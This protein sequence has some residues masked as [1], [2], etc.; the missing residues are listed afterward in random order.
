MSVFRPVRHLLSL[1]AGLALAGLA[2]WMPALAAPWS[3]GDWK[4]NAYIDR[5]GRFSHCMMSARYNSGISLHFL[6][7][8][9]RDLFIGVAAPDWSLDPDSLY[10]MTLT[11]DG[12]R[13][14][15]APGTVLKYD[16]GRL[17]LALGRDRQTRERL[18]QGL[19]LQLLQG[20]RRYAFQLTGT[21]KALLRLE[22]C[23]DEDDARDRASRIPNALSPS[24]PRHRK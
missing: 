5:S 1:S 6:M 16:T 10:P 12:D 13:I 21:A 24:T 14:R 15:S 7:F 22:R 20:D 3:A 4:G 8:P 17:W 19:R 2:G 23:V 18:R 9:N 11:I